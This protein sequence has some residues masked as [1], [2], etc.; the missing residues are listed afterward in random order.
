MEKTITNINQLDLVSGIYTYADYLLWKFEER[1][2]LI[3]GKIFKMSAP[4]VYHQRIVRKLSTAIDIFLK[5]KTCEVF[6]APFDVRLPNKNITV[7]N[8]Y[9]VVQPDLCVV[10]D[11]E[12]I[13]AKGC[14]G[15]PDW[16]IE[17]LSPGNSK[18]EVRYKYQLYEE[19]GVREYWVVRPEENEINIYVL[20]EGAFRALPPFVKGDIVSPIIFP[21]LRI[22]TDELF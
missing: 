14:V 4:T 17:I 19:A 13:D 21:E 8:I 22:D 16:V 2:E 7:N 10:C 18:K 20:E 15:A 5:G 6:I 9:T 3:K 12:K 1:V 11:L